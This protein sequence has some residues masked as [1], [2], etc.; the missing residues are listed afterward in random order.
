MAH[1]QCLA[2][3]ARRHTFP[4]AAIRFEPPSPYKKF[5]FRLGPFAQL[6]PTLEN[7]LVRHLRIRLTGL[8]RGRDEQAVGMVG[9]LRDE[10]PL[11]VRELGPECA[12]PGRLRHP[13]APWRASM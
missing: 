1:E 4:A 8:G 11:L 5:L 13:L 12:T 2:L 3:R 7:H 6:V 10:L 9:K